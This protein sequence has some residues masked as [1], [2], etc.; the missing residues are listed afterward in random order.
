MSGVTESGFVTK[1]YEEIV[2]S[3]ESRFKTKYGDLFDVTEESPDGQNIRIMAKFL[4]DQWQLSE[5]V[6]HGYNPAM[7]SDNALDNL[8]R[9][10]GIARLEN[11]PTRV[12]VQ[13]NATVSLGETVAAGTIVSTVDGIEF[14][15]EADVI[16]PGEGMVYCLTNG[17]I[18]IGPGEITTIKSALPE[19]ITVQNA[20]A[21][22]TGIVRETNTQLRARRERSLVRAGTATAE[23]I[24]AGVADL[25]LEFIAVLENDTDAP[26]NGIPPHSM[27]VVA[28]GSTLPLIAERVYQ[29]KAIGITAYGETIITVV[30]SEGYPQDIG[31]SRPNKRDIHVRCVVKRPVNVAVNKLRKVR[32]ALVDHINGLQIAED[33]EWSKLFCPATE[34]AP[35]LNVRSIEVSLDGATWTMADIPMGVIDRPGADSTIVIVE[36][37]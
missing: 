23:A 11:V 16:T 9:L 2:A 13:F 4:Y 32:D 26:K 7:A 17:A 1:S 10:N 22:I 33:V 35:D 20:E 12:G 21:G 36:E 14:E 30:D 6:Y 28:E 24:Y 5:Q 19:D 37:E 34:A 27:M 3:L 29:N 25:N 15:L 8:V 18:K 31:V